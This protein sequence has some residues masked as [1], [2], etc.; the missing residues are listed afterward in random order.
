MTSRQGDA[1]RN[2]SSHPNGITILHVR[3]LP[4]RPQRG[5][6]VGA[7]LTLPCALGRSGLTRFKREGDGATPVGRM[8][9]LAGFR[10]ADRI[11][12]V[13]AP[14]PLVPIRDDDG[15]CDDLG[16]GRYNRRVRLPFAG[17]H[18]TLRRDDRLYDLVF[19]LDWNVRRRTI[20]RGSA[21]FFHCAR[22]TLEPT[23]GCVAL[24]P[25]D[26]RRLLP[27]LGAKTVLVVG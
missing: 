21:I 8:A 4:G 2:R 10:R 24:R 7:G 6:L 18:E 25:A 9:I 13:P 16:D 20:G 11:L 1:I 23:A 19:V 5:L 14:T 26:M 22:E 17:S 15:W 27:R 12:P 3:P